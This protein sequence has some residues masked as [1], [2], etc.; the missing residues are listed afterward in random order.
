MILLLL[1]RTHLFFD[2]NRDG[3]DFDFVKKLESLT[4]NWII[5]PEVYYNVRH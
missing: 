4:D 1:G 3:E 5:T 2:K